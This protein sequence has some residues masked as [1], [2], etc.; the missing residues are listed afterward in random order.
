MRAQYAAHNIPV[1]TNIVSQLMAAILSFRLPSG[2]WQIPLASKSKQVR[3]NSMSRPA[4]MYGRAFGL[5]L[6]TLLVTYFA[7]Q[8]HV[9]RLMEKGGV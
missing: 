2:T 1:R 8:I 3:I 4:F 6:L 5:S 7:W 9:Q